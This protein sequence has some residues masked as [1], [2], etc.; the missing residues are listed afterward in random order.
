MND[1]IVIRTRGFFSGHQYRH[2]EL[3]DRIASQY[4]QPEK[5]ALAGIYAGFLA[6]Q[7]VYFLYVFIC[8]S[9][10]LLLCGTAS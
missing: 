2:S 8:D 4:R 9:L 3:Q 5:T 1:S 10:S 7:Y 6:E